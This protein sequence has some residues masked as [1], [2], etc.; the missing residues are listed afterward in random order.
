MRRELIRLS[1]AVTSMVALAFLVPLAL[2]VAQTARDRAFAQAE[3]TA[4]ELG[5]ALAITTDR[6]AL[7]RALAASPGGADGLAAVHV[8]DADG[9]LSAIGPSRTRRDQL[10][11]VATSGRAAVVEVPG[12]SALLRPVAVSDARIAVVE[13]FVPASAMNQGVHAAW[14][15]LGGLAAGLVAISVLVADR[16]GSRTVRA[17]RGLAAA[18]RRLG[19]GDLDARAPASDAGAPP[20]V[21]DAAVAFNAMADRVRDLLAAE[22]ELAA[23]LSHRLRTPL[24]ALRLGAAALADDGSADQVQQAVDRLERE[25]DLIIRAARERGA[26]GPVARGCDAADVVRD[27]VAFWSALAED[28]GRPWWL[29]GA[30]E[31]APVPVARAELVAALD[32]LLGNVFQHTGEG[33]GFGVALSVTA[34][35]VTIVVADAGPGIADPAEAVRRGA[36]AGGAGSTGLGLDIARRVADSTGGEL[37]IGRSGLGGADLRLR[38]RTTPGPAAARRRRPSL[39]QP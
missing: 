19:A 14:L 26:G 28:Q 16:L 9:A 7:D 33:V 15:V 11:A 1:I 34:D 35:A 29:T 10:A 4:A 30:D 36:G 18:A 39:S 37:A 5:P 6:A 3:R 22:R 38:L 24:T 20:E 25:V 12:G 31:S 27:R 21:R 17:T 2:I 13:V 23:D 8:P 32:A